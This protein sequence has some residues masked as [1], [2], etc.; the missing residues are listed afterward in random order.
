MPYP[1]SAKIRRKKQREKPTVT[2]GALLFIWLYCVGADKYEGNG[3]IPFRAAVLSGS[4]SLVLL[5]HAG[6][7]VLTF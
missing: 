2:G 3:Q 4:Q 5:R 7:E 6:A 1:C